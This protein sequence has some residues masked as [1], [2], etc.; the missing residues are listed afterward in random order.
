LGLCQPPGNRGLLPVA[1]P[2]GWPLLDLAGNVWEWCVNPYDE[3]G[4]DHPTADVSRV[5]RGGAWFF[6]PMFCR[7]A[8]R[9]HFAPVNRDAHFGFRMCRGAPIEPLRAAPLNIGTLKR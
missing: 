9:V 4:N 1:A 5:L 3:P 2:A 8:Y 7:A 6:D